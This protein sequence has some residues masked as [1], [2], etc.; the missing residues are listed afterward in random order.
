MYIQKENSQLKVKPTTAPFTFCNLSQCEER[1]W[2]GRELQRQAPLDGHFPDVHDQSLAVLLMVNWLHIHHC[3]LDPRLI[4]A[5]EGGGNKQETLFSDILYPNQQ[6]FSKL[7]FRFEASWQ[8]TSHQECCCGESST[9]QQTHTFYTSC[10]PLKCSFNSAVPG[11]A[12]FS[13]KK[14]RQSR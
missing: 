12:L 3:G 5:R 8:L 1:G 13:I 4:L 2:R 10:T 14:T 6:H 7:T 11:A 9:W